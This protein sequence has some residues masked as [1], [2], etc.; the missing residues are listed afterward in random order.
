MNSATDKPKIVVICG[1][2]AIGKTT[3]AIDIAQKINGEI[4]S[5]D[6]MQI[7]RYMD[8][9][10]AKP[11][12]EERVKVF[13]HMIDM[14]DPDEHFDAARFSDLA[15]KRVL[16]IQNRGAVPY[17]VGGTGLYIKSLIHG[18]FQ[19]R[20]VDPAIR[21][22][23]KAEAERFGSKYLHQRL[24]EYD[25]DTAA[26]L[27]PNDAYRIIRALETVEATG[28]SI[29]DYHREHKFGETPFHVLKIGLAMERHLLYDRINHR[30]DAM[31][32]KGLLG[33][34]KS[35]LRKGFSPDLKSMQSIGYRHMVD[36]LQT[37][38]PWDECIRT[39]KRDTR[40]Y[41]KRQITWFNADSEIVWKEQHQ[42]REIASL[43]EDFLGNSI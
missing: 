31:I 27:H 30:V 32:Q 11:T 18:M 43:I 28:K 33:E 9:G 17:V 37:R 12:V 24:R 25:R 16:E 22:R 14:I 19:T 40:R 36:H 38:L 3:V 39:M 6:S 15:R 1:P 29:S 4:I 5:A 42:I 13:H 26:K 34:V 41:A 23:L 20:P 10:T 2:T 21:E 8:I 35:L 7:Y